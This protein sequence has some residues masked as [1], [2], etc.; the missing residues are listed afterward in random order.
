MRLMLSSCLP[1]DP[2]VLLNRRLEAPPED[3]PSAEP[4]K[5]SSPD[6]RVPSC[7]FAHMGASARIATSATLYSHRATVAFMASRNFPEL[8]A[9]SPDYRRSLKP[10]GRHSPFCLPG[11]IVPF[12]GEA[13]VNQLVR[14]DTRC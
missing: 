11:L 9:F 3:V 14:S 4:A 6:N 2:G 7:H 1:S 5:F 8:S 12:R 13:H 10:P